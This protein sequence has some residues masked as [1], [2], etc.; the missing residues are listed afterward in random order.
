[1]MKKLDPLLL[2]ILALSG[3]L[4]IFHL[5]TRSL[6]IDE[7]IQAEASGSKSI[8]EIFSALDTQAA[9]PPLDYLFTRLALFIG[10]GD[11][12]VRLHAAVFGILSVYLVYKIGCLLFNKTVGLISAFMLSVSTYHI[13]YSQE[14]RFYSSLVFFSLLS[15]YLFFK[16]LRQDKFKPWFFFSLGLALGLYTHYFIFFIVMTE[17]LFII[18]LLGLNLVLKQPLDLMNK[19]TAKTLLRFMISSFISFCALIPWF[20]YKGIQEHGPTEFQWGIDTIVEIFTFFSQFKNSGLLLFLVLC[21]GG[22]IL[23]S[24][25]DIKGVIFLLISLISI[26]L[27]L[28]LVVWQKYFFHH[29]QVIFVLPFF[30]MLVSTGI[31][32]ISRI[33]ARLLTIPV[34]KKSVQNVMRSSFVVVILVLISVKIHYPSVKEYFNTDKIVSHAKFV[35]DWRGMVK[36]IINNSPEGSLVIYNFVD[37]PRIPHYYFTWLDPEEDNVLVNLDSPTSIRLRIMIQ[38]PKI[39]YIFDESSKGILPLLSNDY[40]VSEFQGIFTLSRD[41]RRY[42]ETG[43]DDAI[44]VCSQYLLV[45]S[46]RFVKT[47]LA[48]L[49]NF[50]NDIQK[51]EE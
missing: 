39:W 15:V 29:R 34:R 2:I 13:L 1:M 41:I 44:H 23:S 17:G 47:E 51:E 28:H 5:G 27:V 24:K 18:I 8:L 14:A 49:Q 22:I 12:F 32:N 45:Y 48:N 46:N 33:F 26:P 19:V 10:E 50:K 16:A 43:L 35:A 20:V 25:K 11:F 6:W 37:F 7:A 21:L 36:H 4:R 3:F 30:L 40:S 38:K 42:A 31:Y 9:S